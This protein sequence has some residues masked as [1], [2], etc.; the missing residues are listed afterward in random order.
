LAR[1]DETLIRWFEEAVDEINEK[2]SEKDYYITK[3]FKKCGLDFRVKGCDQECP[4]AF[5][6][7]LD[8]LSEDGLYKSLTAAHEA[9]KLD[10]KAPLLLLGSNIVCVY[11]S[12]ISECS[13]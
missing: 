7:H 8:N 10:G 11:C 12:F 2:Q 4:A 13:S 1:R 6:V 9:T 3:G 5:K